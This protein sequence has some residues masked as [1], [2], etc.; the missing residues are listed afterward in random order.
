M[1]KNHRKKPCL[2]VFMSLLTLLSLTGSAQNSPSS[3]PRDTIMQAAFEI[4]KST[5]YC[6]FVTVDSAGQPQVRTMN[7]FPMEDKISIWFA[8][9]RTSRKVTEIKRNPKVSV[10]FADHMQAKGYV[11]ITGTAEILD[12]KELLVKMKRAYWENIPDWQNVFVLIR[13][14]PKTL[15][16]INYNRGITGHPGTNR[17]PTLVF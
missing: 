7:P 13:I 12:D 2:Y 17:S 9:S 14:T 5:P 4:I 10:Y 8:T 3:I 1:Q 6:A 16:V 11:N 15:D